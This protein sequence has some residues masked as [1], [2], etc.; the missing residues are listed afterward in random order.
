METFRLRRMIKVALRDKRAPRDP[1]A[2]LPLD[3]HVRS[4]PLLAPS[5]R[6]A[7]C[8]TYSTPTGYDCGKKGL[9][10]PDQLMRRASRA[11]VHAT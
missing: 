10:R 3:D 7:R 2:D 4:G 1:Q 9:G 6:S 11:R 5:L 8:A